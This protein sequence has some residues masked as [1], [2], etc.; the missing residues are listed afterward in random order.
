MAN[1]LI[2]SLIT[3]VYFCTTFPERLLILALPWALTAPT[4][5]LMLA[6]MFRRNI[7]KNDFIR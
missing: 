4:A 3:Y 7:K 5:M 2:T 6:R 1:A